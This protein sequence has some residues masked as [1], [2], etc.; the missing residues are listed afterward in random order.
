MERRTNVIPAAGWVLPISK[1]GSNALTPGCLKALDPAVL[2]V[3]GGW[4]RRHGTVLKVV[5]MSSQD[6]ITSKWA[7]LFRSQFEH[8]KNMFQ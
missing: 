3:I 5:Q 8:A 7:R 6:K 2:W 4:A 1:L